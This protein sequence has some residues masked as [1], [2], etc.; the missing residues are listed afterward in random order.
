MDFDGFIIFT[1]SVF[2]FGTLSAMIID[3][4]SYA[5]SFV[6]ESFED[7]PLYSN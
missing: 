1:G 2:I 4:I 7:H 6:G 5:T 3:A